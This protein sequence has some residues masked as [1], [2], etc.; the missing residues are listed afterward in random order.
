MFA[1]P[2]KD[3]NDVGKLKTD[4]ED[5]AN[6]AAIHSPKMH[7]FVS[8]FSLFCVILALLIPSDNGSVLTD[9]AESRAVSARTASLHKELEAPRRGKFIGSNFHARDLYDAYKEIQS[10]YYQKALGLGANDWKILTRKEGVEISMMEHASDPTCP[11]VRM[12]VVIPTPVEDCW[13]FLQLANWDETMVNMDPFYEGV[14][15]HGEFTYRHTHMILARKRTQR[16]LAFGK[17]D[18]VFLSVS[19]QPMKDGTWVSGSVSV[20]T[21]IL[22]SQAGYT[23]GYQ[24][25]IAFYKPL[26][27]NQKTHVTIVCRIDL[28]DSTDGGLG[29]FMPM[30]LYVK[31]IGATGA[32]SV[33]SMRKALEEQA[34]KR[35]QRLLQEGEIMIKSRVPGLWKRLLARKPEME[36]NRIL[37][38]DKVLGKLPWSKNTNPPEDMHARAGNLDRRVTFPGHKICQR[39]FSKKHFM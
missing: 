14:S 15:L 5:M 19:D 12:T 38:A 25:S 30:W 27:N 17:R 2:R 7:A 22:P 1:T 16:I 26:E 39:L 31:T 10:E 37:F 23:R 3:S 13:E 33:L 4:D 24:D 35:M 32:R 11:Y 18:F 28:N 9:T 8:A 6:H 29:G 34:V 36:A 20:Q 21:P